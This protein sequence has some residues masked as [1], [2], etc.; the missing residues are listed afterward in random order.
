M[1][2][3]AQPSSSPRAINL[4]QRNAVLANSLDMIS[5]VY[6]QNINPANQSI[7]SINPRNVGLLKKFIIKVTGTLNSGANALTLTDFGLANFFSQIQFN[8]LNNYTR[9]QT[10]GWHL[11][12]LETLRGKFPV[13]GAL[14]ETS[15]NALANFGNNFGVNVIPASLTANN[16]TPFTFYLEVPIAYTDEDLRGAIYMN[17]VNAVA[18]LNLTLNPAAF[19]ATGSDSTS[20]CYIGAGGSFTNVSITVYQNYLDQLPMG[21]NGVVLPSIDLGTIYELK[22]TP[23]PAFVANNDNP[24]PYAN[25]RDFLSVFLVYNHDGSANSG[26][27][28]GTDLN[29]LALQSANF[30]NIQKVDPITQAFRTRRILNADLPPGCYYFSHRKQPVSTTMYGNMQL[31]VNPITAAA[32]NYSLVGWED[33]GQANVLVKAGS[34]AG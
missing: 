5:S 17:V 12:F 30:L 25:F 18:T 19:V 13:G 14:I 20:A 11:A 33:F 1:P 31:I 24:I 21:K 34:L 7:V 3:T 6:S 2:P 16:S 28:G 29:Y 10:T 23:M 8:D 22:N 27:V 15:M 26:R 4:A 9:I 32:Q